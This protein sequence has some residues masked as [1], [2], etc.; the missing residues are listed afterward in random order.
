MLEVVGGVLDNWQFFKR[1]NL[2]Q[3][4]TEWQRKWNDWLCA[5]FFFLVVLLSILDKVL[6]AF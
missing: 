3:Y 6:E 2:T 1:A 4:K 5:F